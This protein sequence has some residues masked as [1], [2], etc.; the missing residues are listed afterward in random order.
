MIIIILPYVL[1]MLSKL[2]NEIIK[3]LQYLGTKMFMFI[4]ENIRFGYI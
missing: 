4:D 3:Q 2:F 1:K